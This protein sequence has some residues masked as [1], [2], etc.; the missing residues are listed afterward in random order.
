MVTVLVTSYK[1]EIIIYT[2]FFQ[3]IYPS[4]ILSHDIAGFHYYT[5]L[6]VNPDKQIKCLCK[7]LNGL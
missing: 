2:W 3:I 4:I 1:I 7:L 5:I 6:K